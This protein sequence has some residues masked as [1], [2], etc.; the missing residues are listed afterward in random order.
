MTLIRRAAMATALVAALALAACGS[1]NDATSTAGGGTTAG[2][3]TS[4]GA[5]TAQSSA[6]GSGSADGGA[7]AG[8]TW[9]LTEAT[10]GSGKVVAADSSAKS[11][12]TFT[13]AQMA[14]FTGCNNGGATVTVSDTQLV[15][16]PMAM[17]MM[18]CT[19]PKVTELEHLI[20]S[21]FAA[22]ANFSLAG[23]SLTISNDAGSLVYQADTA[24]S[25]TSSS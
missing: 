24:A 21:V 20:G 10:D 9:L 17:T 11:T 5:T 22:P 18:A 12:L 19:D 14:V 2:T 15:A 1:S 13:G 23:E 16:G 8:T 25:V 6:T 4:P 3:A 7:L